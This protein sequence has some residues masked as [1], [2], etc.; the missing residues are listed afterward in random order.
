MQTKFETTAYCKD[1]KLFFRN[2]AKI[3]S[4]CVSSGVVEFDVTIEK[5]KKHRSVYQNRYYFGVV[6]A[7]IRERFI[8]L[9]NDVNIEET[10]DYLK[11]E[12][13]YKEFVNEK[14][15]EIIRIP[16]STANLTTSEFMDYIDKIQKF[17]SEILD[18]YIPEPN[19]QI[20]FDLK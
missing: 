17:A 15:A 7:L 8:E 11:H 12:F 5:K 9:G 1:G 16:K 18:I 4:E 3:E 14:T 10:H 19:S 2:K 6:V 13:N 20:S